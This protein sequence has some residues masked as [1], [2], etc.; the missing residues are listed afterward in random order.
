MLMINMHAKRVKKRNHY[1]HLEIYNIRNN[2]I[3][4]LL[5]SSCRFPYL[6]SLTFEEVTYS[7]LS[8]LQVIKISIEATHIRM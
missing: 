4:F 8:N 2:Q 1:E 6:V 7:S 3:F 5:A